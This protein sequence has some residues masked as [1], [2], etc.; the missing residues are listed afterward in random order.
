MSA[1]N[2]PSNQIYSAK[3]SGVD[4]YEFLHPTGSIMKRK[5]DDWVNATHILKAAKF[6]KAKRT[7]ILEKEVITDVHEKVQGGFGK[8]QGTWVP[9]DIAR[10]LAQKFEV[11]EELKPLFDFT[12]RDGTASPPQAPKHHH[13]S[14]SDPLKRRAAKSPS[15]S[16]N[17]SEPAVPKRRGRPPRKKKLEEDVSNDAAQMGKH[18]M[19]GFPRPSIPISLI[20]SNQLPLIQSAFHKNIGNEQSGNH[21]KPHRQQLQQKYEELDIEDGLSSDIEANIAQ[22]MGQAARNANTMNTALISGKEEHSSSSSSLPSSP[23]DFSA[24]MAFDTQRVGSATSPF[25]TA[26]PR[27]SIPSR[28]PNTDL[29]QKANEYITKLVNYFINSELQSSNSI[30]MELL[31]PPH[32]TPYIDAWID[33]EHHT[34]FHWACA[35]GELPIVEVLLQAGSNRRA[36]NILGETPLTRASIFHNSYTKRTYPRIF[37]LLQDTV[38]D[39]DSRSQ[40]VI[41]HIVKRKSSTPS[42]LYYLDVVLSKIKDF[43]PQYRIE[44]LINTQDDKGNTPLHIAAMNGDRKFFQILTGNDA[45]TTI[46]NHAGVTADELI[47]NKFDKNSHLNNNHGYHNHSNGNS[48]WS[49]NTAATSTVVAAPAIPTSSSAKNDILPSEASATVSKAIPEVVGLM[50]DLAN[51]YQTLHQDRNQELRDL[52]KVLKSINN[53]VVAV[54]MKISEILDVKSV[55]QVC[56]EIDNLKLYTLELQHKYAEQQKELFGILEKEQHLELQELVKKNQEIKHNKEQSGSSV[57]SAEAPANFAR[58]I[59]ALTMLQ[60]Q[61]KAKMKRLLELLCGNDR[62]HKFKKMIAQGTDVELGDVDNFLDIILQQLNEEK[63]VK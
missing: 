55:D 37:Q 62:L 6:A 52:K 63:Q 41:H 47:N 26:L 34:A 60:F 27:Y 12:Q 10:R 22:S 29:D 45:L 24:P 9:L 19:A 13:A 2:G 50:K 23:T 42:T 56:D 36:T 31:H 40:T 15:V 17:F 30:P 7:R 28:P 14:R 49:L 48:I 44:T 21:N 54:D 33:S 58:E 38:F 20:S 59:K 61:R 8:Y 35:M 46:K 11:L 51:S 5:A 25:G 53:S 4:V 16:G 32:G 39:L 43:S 1:T 57:T 18:E 3:Y